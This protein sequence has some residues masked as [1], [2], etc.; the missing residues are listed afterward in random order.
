MHFKNIPRRSIKCNPP[1]SVPLPP[2][3]TEKTQNRS[4]ERRLQQVVQGVLN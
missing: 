3:T 2:P 4:S 1:F